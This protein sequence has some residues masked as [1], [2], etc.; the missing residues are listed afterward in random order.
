M[1]FLDYWTKL[2]V[3]R[4]SFLF[5]LLMSGLVINLAIGKKESIGNNITI[6]FP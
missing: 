1:I 3:G 2:L 5:E 4:P 6:N